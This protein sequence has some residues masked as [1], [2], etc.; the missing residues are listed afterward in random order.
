MHFFRYY[1]YRFFI[2]DTLPIPFALSTPMKCLVTDDAELT[3][4]I[5]AKG[6]DAVMLTFR[7]CLF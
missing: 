7:A 1:R 2:L 5:K 3:L 6:N 4:E